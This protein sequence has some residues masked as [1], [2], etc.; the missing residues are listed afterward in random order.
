M[1]LSSVA[2]RLFNELVARLPIF[3]SPRATSDELN[4][5]LTQTYDDIKNDRLESFVELGTRKRHILGRSVARRAA[6]KLDAALAAGASPKF[7][8]RATAA[9]LESRRLNPPKRRRRRAR[10]VTN[11]PA[12]RATTSP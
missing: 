1:S 11:A 12:R 5:G 2:E 8:E 7:T 6:E 4:Q 3:M 9:S 10:Q